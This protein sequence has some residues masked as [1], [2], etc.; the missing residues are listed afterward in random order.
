MEVWGEWWEESRGAGGGEGGCECG[1]EARLGGGGEAL[2][3]LRTGCSS[4]FAASGR[5]AASL[6]SAEVIK[7]WK[8][9]V[10]SVLASS[11]GGG[12]LTILFITVNILALMS[13][14]GGLICA[15]SMSVMPS[16]QMSTLKSYAEL[17]IS[18]AIQSG[19]PITVSV[20][21]LRG[22]RQGSRGQ[23]R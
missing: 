4:S 9:G 17:S 20:F 11:M 3:S 13:W 1:C 10:A 7:W 16:D 21:D 19:V 15:S 14:C 23:A 5:V 22:G 18:G 6:T 12:P 2:G 8:A